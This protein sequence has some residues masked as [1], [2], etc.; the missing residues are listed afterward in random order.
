MVV[1][2]LEAV[3][4]DLLHIGP[5]PH[6]AFRQRMRKFQELSHVLALFPHHHVLKYILINFQLDVA[7]FLAGAQDGFAHDCG[8]VEL[9]VREI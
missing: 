4:P 5:V 7:D 8:D 1:Y 3:V 2:F 6:N 9:R